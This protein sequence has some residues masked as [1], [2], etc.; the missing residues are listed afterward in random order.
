MKKV[1]ITSLHLK[2]GGVE[3]AISLLANALIKRG[4]KVT[5]LCTYNFGTPAY[6]LDERITIEN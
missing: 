3:M 6:K 4:Y 1:Y 5:I 2:H